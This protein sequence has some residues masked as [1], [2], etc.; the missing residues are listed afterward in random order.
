MNDY[1]VLSNIDLYDILCPPKVKDYAHK[2][3][4]CFTKGDVIY[5]Q[6]QTDEKI[7]LVSK[8]KVKLVN[9]DEQGNEIVKHILVKGEVFGEN[10][11]LHQSQR[12][13]FAIACEKD[14][15]V[16]S[17]NLTAMQELMRKNN[18]FSTTIYKLIGYRLK[19]VERRLE[20]LIGKAVPARI[21]SFLYDFYTETG[22]TKFQHHLSQKDIAALLATSRESVAKVFNQLKEEKV[23]DYDRRSV[24]ILNADKLKEISLGA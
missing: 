5:T 16:C 18:Q 13:E 7:Y 6:K 10:I 14:T 24:E 1:W 22:E 3:G 12:E 21:A 11:I 19:K 23:I 15:T 17:L 2:F 4:S 20:L 8:G 9:Y